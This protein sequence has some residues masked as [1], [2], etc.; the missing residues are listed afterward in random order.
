M[1]QCTRFDSDIAN[2]YFKVDDCNYVVH[3][4]RVEL[5]VRHLLGGGG[6]QGSLIWY[7][8]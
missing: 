8:M 2:N 1:H 6:L 7:G 5:V 3:R 4:A